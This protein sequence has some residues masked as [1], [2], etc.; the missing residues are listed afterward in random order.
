[1]VMASINS[2]MRGVVLIALVLT[3]TGASW[4]QEYQTGAYFKD[5][6]GLMMSGFD[7]VSYHQQDTPIKGQETIT[8]TY[9][10]VTF[11]F[12]TEANRAVFLKEPEQYVPRFGGFCAFGLG[13]D[14]S[15]GYPPGRYKS[16]PLS[17]KIVD[18]HLHLFYPP[19][20]WPA[21]DNWN[22]NETAVKQRANRLW[23]E[24]R[25]N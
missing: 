5:T 22:R 7:P 10:G 2:N 14:P 16:D 4:A 17:Y 19:D 18:G 24:I 13:M 15:A 3:M 11:W 23:Q 20:E 8:A 25:D 1:M 6:Q 9:D 21:L 12:A